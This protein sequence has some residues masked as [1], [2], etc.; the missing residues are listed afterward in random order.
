MKALLIALV[1]SV[2]LFLP[3]SFPRNQR[4][5]SIEKSSSTQPK[6]EDPSQNNPP[7][8]SVV[9]W[10]EQDK[11]QYGEKFTV[12]LNIQN[13]S[14]STAYNVSLRESKPPE[15]AFNVSGKLNITWKFLKPGQEV[16]HRY[17]LIPTLK[18][19][20]TVSLGKTEVSWYSSDGTQYWGFS[21]DLKVDIQYA[22]EKEIKWTKI[23]RRSLIGVVIVLSLAIVPL[24]TI[25]W[26]TLQKYRKET[27]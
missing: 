26:R 18:S 5:G 3:W 15:W 14:N 17:Q 12:T 25:E 24:L 6:Q 7:I 4:I 23:W 9:K 16:N 21:E 8:L 1:I 19:D 10:S 13:N 27:K 22:G 2:P 11:V 20:K